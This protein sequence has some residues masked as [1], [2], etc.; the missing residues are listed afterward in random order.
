[1][2]H[3]GNEKSAVQKPSPSRYHGPAVI[4]EGYAGKL[5]IIVDGNRGPAFAPT[6]DCYAVDR[7]AAKFAN[8]ATLIGEMHKWLAT[9]GGMNSIKDFSLRSSIVP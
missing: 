3:H 9:N 4:A 5:S 2:S 6:I 7:A 1:M 8:V